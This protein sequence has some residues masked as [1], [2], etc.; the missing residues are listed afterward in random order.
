[1]ACLVLVTKGVSRPCSV[2]KR[3]RCAF[4]NGVMGH[5]TPCFELFS[6][7][8]TMA[9]YSRHFMAFIA[10]FTNGFYGF[11]FHWNSV[12]FTKGVKAV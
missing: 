9:L 3:L 1:M 2:Y 8:G 4:T 7:M 5:C 6:Q 11:V 10:V 12:V